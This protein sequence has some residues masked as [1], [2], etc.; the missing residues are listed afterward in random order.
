MASVTSEQVY[1]YALATTLAEEGGLSEHAADMGG[2]TYRG[3]TTVTYNA[4]R[5]ARG[6]EPQDVALISQAELEDVYRSY[7]TA[8]D[9]DTLPPNLAVVAFDVSINSGPGR[10]R[11]WLAEG[12]KTAS[13][14][15]ARRLQ[16][17]TELSTWDVFGKGWTRRAG[18]VL[19]AAEG[20]GTA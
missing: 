4:Y 9:G 15:T 14:F 18:R 7:W 19:M 5:A 6:L 13:A 16:H 2:R 8:I 3:V 10:A 11:A 20:V 1:R 12:H 17:Y